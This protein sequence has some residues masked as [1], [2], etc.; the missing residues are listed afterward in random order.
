M[1]Y[2]RQRWESYSSYSFLTSTLYGGEWS[3]SHPGRALPPGKDPHHTHW[4]EGWVGLRAGLDTEPREKSF[5]SARDRTL[6]MQSVVR[7]ETD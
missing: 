3:V 5:A 2:R 4:T 1:P 6:V 7:H